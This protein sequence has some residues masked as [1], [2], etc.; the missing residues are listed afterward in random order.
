MQNEV[1]IRHAM[2]WICDALRPRR[3]SVVLTADMT[4]LPWRVSNDVRSAMINS[5][6]VQPASEPSLRS[7]VNQMFSI[8]RGGGSE[9]S[10]YLCALL[11]AAVLLCSLVLLMSV[12]IAVVDDGWCR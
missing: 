5:T 10:S 6:Q 1:R 3:L 7:P 9:M 8:P 4:S 11:D 12:I 2:H